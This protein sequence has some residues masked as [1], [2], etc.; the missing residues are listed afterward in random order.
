MKKFCFVS[1]LLLGVLL[2]EV[3]LAQDFSNKGKDFWVGYGYHQVMTNG[4]QQ[5]MVL[6]FAADQNT[7]VTV[8]IPG[9][10]YSQTYFVAANTVLTSNP[11]PKGGAG[12]DARLLTES[13]SPE[14]KGIHIEADKPIVAYAH[15]Y[16]NS[17]SGA[18]ILY[19]TNVLGKEYYSINYKNVSNTDNANCWF[20]VIACDPGT[21]TVEITPSENTLFHPAGTPFT[22]TLQQGQVYN[23]MG[24]L[25]RSTGSVYN[26]VDLTGSKIQSI[27]TGGGCKRIA[28]FS[29]SGRIAI[30]CNGTAPSSDNYMV[31]SLPKS[32]WGK[33]FLTSFTGGTS[34][35][36]I[37]R[38]CV[39]TPAANVTINGAPIT[40]PLQA[41]FYYEVPITSQPMRI[42]SDQP[43]TVA[44]YLTSQ[45]ACGNGTPGD[46]EVIYLSPV[47]QNINKVL[48]NATSNFAI[49]Q[50]Y[51][52]VIIPNGGTAI[53]SFKLDGL[54]VAPGSFVTHPQ[55]PAY[56]YL[57]QNVSA[58]QHTVVSDSGFNA[59]AYG[60]GNAESY[61]YNAGTNIKDIYQY[62]SIA[63]QYATVNFPA[64]CQN[65][66]FYFSMTFPYQPTHIKWQFNG[67][68]PD[69]DIAS[70]VP[71]GT[72]V[73]NGRTLYLYKLPTP[74][75]I[76]TAGTYPIKVIAEN[77][78]P[79]GCGGEQEI[80]FDVQVFAP[81]TADFN[82]TNTGCITSPVQFT[83]ASST[84]GR[85]ITAWRW[86]F[87]DLT[88]GTTN[89]P[90]HT[91]GAAG[92]YTVK[93][94][95]ITDVGCVSNEA[96]KTV[97]LSDA[98][99]AKFAITNSLCVGNSIQF[100]DQSTVTGGGTIVKWTWDFGDGSPVVVSG[101]NAGQAHVYATAGTYTAKLKVQTNTGCES[102]VFTMP[103]V[104][105]PSPVADFANP[106]VCLPSGSTQFTD[107]SNGSGGTIVSWAWD[108]GDG[109]TDIAQNPV[110][111][112]ATAGPF[113]ATLKVTT[114]D[115]C[116]NTVSKAIT[117]IYAQPHADFTVNSLETCLG[118]QSSFTDA[119]TAPASSAAQW[120]WDFD[121]AGATSNSQNPTHTFTTAGVHNVK[122]YIKSAVGCISDIMTKAVTV[123]P[124][125]T[126]SFTNSTPLC[127]AGPITF[128]STSTPNAGAFTTYAWTV[129]TTPQGANNPV[130]TYTPTAPGTYT[131][132]LTASTDKG[133]SAS[134]TQAVTV[135]PK[136]VANFSLPTICL[137]AGTANFSS[138]STIASGS[139][140]GYAWD[141]GDAATGTGASVTHNYSTVGPFNVSL[142]VTSDQGCTDTKTQALNT[143]YAEPQAA[144]SAPPEVCNGAPVTFTESSTAP[145]SSVAQWQWDF[146]DGNTDVAQN[147]TH[148]YA[149]PGTYTVT[150]NV[151]SAIGCQTVNN[152]ATHTVVVNALPTADFTI[153]T[154]GC[155]NQDITFTDGSVPNSGTVTKWSW[156]FG[157]GGTLVQTAAG[158]VLH[159]YTTAG[160]YNVTLQVQT[161]KGCM[162]TIK[163]KQVAVHVLPV[164][165]FT[166]PQACLNDV[167]APFTDQ[168]TISAGSVAGW[169]W[170]FGDG[171]A[172]PGNPNTSLAQ[173]PTHHYTVAGSYTAQ[174][175][176]V[177][178]QGCTNTKSMTFFVNGSVPVAGFAVQNTGGL[179]SNLPVSIKDGSGVD[180]GSLIKTEIFWDYT[181][182]PTIKDVN[183]APASGATYM[184]QYPEF[185]TPASKTV[186]IRYV[187][188]SGATCSN[189][190]DK[191]I[192]L[193]ATPQLAFA[194]VPPV[195]EDAPAFQVTQAQILNGPPGGTFT[196]DGISTTGLFTPSVAGV[197][198]HTITYSYT[199]ANGCTN[200]KTQVIAVN[201][202]PV[203]TAGPDKFMLEGGKV[204]LT[205]TL[206]PNIVPT[207]TW[208]PASYLD[209]PAASNPVASPPDDITY[210]LTVTSDKGCKTTDDV[211]VK[212]LKAP[213]IPNIFSP[214]GDGVHDRWEIPYLSTYPGCT[215][216]VYNRY[217]QLIY[218]SVGYDTPWDGKVKGSEV[219]VGTYYYIIDPKNGR[220]RMSGYVDIIR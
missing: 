88:T 145:G 94:S 108:F 190:Y 76:P 106:N 52:N 84:G 162:S 32:A 26:G 218:H 161:D 134:G 30:S 120:F 194:A 146:G 116:E 107:N 148:T 21:T 141:F 44:Q 147:P 168:S 18:T 123:N 121:D 85:A 104:I 61:G 127:E 164:A 49:T 46:P 160:T 181:N 83:D 150:L 62:I 1:T 117:N 142:T 16:N 38:I 53:S 93:Y 20:Y 103:V 77:P 89:N 157:D 9:I 159:K 195:C 131:V 48:W 201:R 115:G 23:L 8:S 184:H 217:G 208:T 47:E 215:I 35:N 28:V 64:T 36:N 203:I 91:Y 87:G 98:P 155:E 3:S 5:E 207:Y 60:Y 151:K 125:P 27:N 51:I 198:P 154:P 216:D 187:V 58:G 132:G 179:C 137:P 11:I 6:Y 12:G 166:P 152:S 80:D 81:P 182:D 205:P 86:D 66:P 122:L 197:G 96:S 136:P 14:V 200:S 165:D 175:T 129:N 114:S 41:N 105:H 99:I 189:T 214:N 37:F 199:D 97:T 24:A 213:V 174:L 153:G 188:Y 133:C 156:D 100:T 90:S 139:I 92:N 128:T 78:T 54:P 10:G 204:E 71:D 59:I 101:T 82:F 109:G 69:V 17:V 45:G 212:V 43:V 209:N 50:H 143:I 191:V 13:T 202:K 42:E 178:D 176:A 112:Y 75:T 74:Y 211:F 138:S 39:S 63:N 126:I 31:Q 7:N 124:L 118:A 40:Y 180:I 56:S 140:T 2:G 68:F 95:I 172:T 163:S 193:L 144:F 183:N 111:V 4:N 173:N 130:L 135:N 171:N 34:P 192:T 72:S 102:V 73:V 149:A 185:A 110:H 170:D 113:T 169:S 167:A 177:S 196:G 67:L 119:S 33:K 186:T 220:A 219:P 15:I 55:D 158:P 25:S 79:D 206:D 210:T 29:G 22:I 70:P 19:P 65:S 57:V